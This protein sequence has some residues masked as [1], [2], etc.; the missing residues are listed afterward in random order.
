MAS[1]LYEWK[2][3]S[4][5]RRDVSW[6]AFSQESGS[7][8][9]RPTYSRLRMVRLQKLILEMARRSQVHSFKV[10]GAVNCCMGHVSMLV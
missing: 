1:G 3:L 7:R 2:L 10:S 6:G 8:L 5:M 4:F 9:Y